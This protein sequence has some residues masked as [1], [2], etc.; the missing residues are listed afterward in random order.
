VNSQS[1]L[2]ICIQALTVVVQMRPRSSIKR[3]ARCIL[4]TGLH[5]WAVTEPPVAAARRFTGGGWNVE[6]LNGPAA[7]PRNAFGATL[8]QHV[9]GALFEAKV[10]AACSL[11]LSAP[12]AEE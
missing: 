11:H 2:E 8:M 6:P 4:C 3:K 10:G 1:L 7:T 5:L 9:G 12:G